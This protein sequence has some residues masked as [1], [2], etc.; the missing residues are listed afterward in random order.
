M[1]CKC[2]II[3]EQNTCKCLIRVEYIA[4][5]WWPQLMCKTIKC[6][7]VYLPYP[8]A[9]MS[10]IRIDRH[11]SCLDISLLD[12]TSAMQEVGGSNPGQ[13]MSVSSYFIEGWRE[14]LSS[15]S[16]VVTLTWFTHMDCKCLI[17]Q[18]Q[19]TCKCLIRVEWFAIIWWSLLMCKA[20]KCMWVYLPYP[21][22]AMSGIRIDRHVSCLDISLLDC[23]SA[24]Q[25]VGGSNPGQYMSVSR[26]FVEGWREP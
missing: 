16:I 9:A 13:Y 14:P 26:Y 8:K 24:M 22:A 1:G 25:E 21:G 7:W 6:M 19:N 15:L 11:V 4:I 10:G 20:I 3:Q 12:C 17:I 2:L 5:I 23:M 18:E